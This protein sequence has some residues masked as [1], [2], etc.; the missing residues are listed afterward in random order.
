MKKILLI[1]AAIGTIA[2]APAVAV[3]KCVELS[4]SMLGSADSVYEGRDYNAYS[5]DWHAPLYSDTNV[6]DIYGVAVCAH[7]TYGSVGSTSEKL[8]FNNEIMYNS[9]CHCKMTSPAVSQWV[10]AHAPNGAYSE[11]TAM[12]CLQNCGQYC[13]NAVGYGDANVQAMFNNLSD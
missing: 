12:D 11:A 7:N 8:T 5:P 1:T 9:K 4:S 13:A 6:V 2:T 3:Q 10:V